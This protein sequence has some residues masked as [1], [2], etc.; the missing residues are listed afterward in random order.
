MT[1]LSVT[2]FLNYYKAMKKIIFPIL[3]FAS[4]FVF[5]A[6]TEKKS[7]AEKV[8][9]FQSTLTNED[10][11]AMLNM[12]DECMEQLK[13]GKIDEVLSSLYEY[14]DSTETVSQLSE[15]TNK[16]YK[17][18]FTMFPVKEYTREYY[19]F[20]MQGLND[21]RYKVKFDETESEDDGA[22]ITAY[23]F[24]PVKIDG[25]WYVTVKRADQEI[26]ESRN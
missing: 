2:L 18:I 7:K 8:S 1:R 19:S 20:Q 22:F 21:V 25:T 10:T 14:D 6:C 13:A 5:F 4:I 26:D 15:E 17:K 11:V 9:E 3:L 24:N 16:R 23:M 12:C